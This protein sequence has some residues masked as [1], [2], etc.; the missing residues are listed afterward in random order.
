VGQYDVDG[1]HRYIYGKTRKEVAAKLTKAIAERDAG[2]VF[3]AG[4]LRLGDYLDRWLDSIRDTLRG[5]S[6]GES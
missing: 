1:K 6:L 2:M 4:S 5:I 3:D